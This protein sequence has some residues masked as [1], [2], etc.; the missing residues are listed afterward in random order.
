MVLME[1]FRLEKNYSFHFTICYMLESFDYH[2]KYVQNVPFLHLKL[3][4]NTH[5]LMMFDDVYR[6]RSYTKMLIF[7]SP[8]HL[9]RYTECNVWLEVHLKYNKMISNKI[10][11]LCQNNGTHNL[12][13]ISTYLSR[14]VIA[15]LWKIPFFSFMGELI[16]DGVMGDILGCKMADF[17]AIEGFR[18][19]ISVILVMKISK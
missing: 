6:V 14:H 12:H 11:C 16:F 13:F 1:N 15:Y 7:F 4:L 2:P 10:S 9:W 18:F 5:M 19:I 17:M 8:N 3:T